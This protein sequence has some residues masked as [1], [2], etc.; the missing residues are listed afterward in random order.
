MA[1]V[2]PGSAIEDE[3][4][5]RDDRRVASAARAWER[6]STARVATLATLADPYGSRLVPVCF[7]TRE[8]L[9]LFAVD[10]VK[11][12]RSRRLE[13]LAD[14]E[15]DP[16]VALLAHHY[17]DADWGRLWWVRATGRA[18]VV[19]DARE[20][21]RAL[22]EL[23]AKYPQYGTRRPPGPVVAVEVRSIRLWEAGGAR[24]RGA[25]DESVAGASPSTDM[26]SR[27]SSM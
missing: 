14:I 19:V 10:D 22:D 17:D 16:R 15:R 21:D 3:A 26:G 7:V 13:R 20:A 18:H 9:V 8:P 12:K 1:P 24:Q 6:L 23:A 11:P 27:T 5:T 4:T 25:N 2:P